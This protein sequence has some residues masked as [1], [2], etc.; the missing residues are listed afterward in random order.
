MSL[1]EL[2][3]W[4]CHNAVGSQRQ[5]LE[6]LTQFLE[7]H[8]V[9][10]HSKTAD[11]FDRYYNGSTWTA[12]RPTWNITG[13]FPLAR[14]L[15]QSQLHLLRLAENPCGEPRADHLPGHGGEPRRWRRIA[16]ENYAREL[17]ELFC[18]GVDNGY[19]QNDI[20]AMSRAWTGWT[21]HI[22]EREN[23]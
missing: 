7:N 5:L 1:D 20:V 16:N 15:A 12:L 21:V 19:D 14:G 23:G 4:H 9:T 18:M 2:R 17:F 3:R 13:S 22:V 8:F 11:Y 10:Y 6:V